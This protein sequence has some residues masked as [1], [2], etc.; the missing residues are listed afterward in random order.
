MDDY[1]FRALYRKLIGHYALSPDMAE[2][3]LQCILKRLAETENKT[4]NS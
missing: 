1:V 4:E 2:A 3:V